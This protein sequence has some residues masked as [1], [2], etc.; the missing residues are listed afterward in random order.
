MP[1]EPELVLFEAMSGR[2]ILAIV[3]DDLAARCVAPLPSGE[4]VIISIISVAPTARP[5]SSPNCE[6]QVY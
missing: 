2:R 3:G 6:Q 4:A 1:D 5:P